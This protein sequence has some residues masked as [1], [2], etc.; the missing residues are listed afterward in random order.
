MKQDNPFAKLGALEQK[1]Y[2]QTSSE[3]AEQKPENAKREKRLN[4]KP[5][6]PQPPAPARQLPAKPL[7]NSG[8]TRPFIK[9]T[10][11]LYEDQLDYL[12]R[13]ALQDRLD[14]KEASMNA[15]V[16]QAIDEWIAR[17]KSNK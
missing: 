17:R 16:R 1:L 10:F 3:P 8:P 12:S 14:G 11:D 6:S 9:R 13:E 2:H 5:V 15:W 4:R 7:A